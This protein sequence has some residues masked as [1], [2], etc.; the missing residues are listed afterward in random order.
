MKRIPFLLLGVLLT[1]ACGSKPIEAKGNGFSLTVP[2]GWRLTYELQG[3]KRIP[4]G[5]VAL[6]IEE[7]NDPKTPPTLI[8]Q[9]I[10]PKIDV[11]EPAGCKQ[12]GAVFGEEEKAE[13]RRT[14]VVDGSRGKSCEAELFFTAKNVVG[15]LMVVQT[16]KTTLLA[17]C[18]HAP[19]ENIAAACRRIVDTIKLD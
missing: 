1:Q 13:V 10:T 11:F 5:M 12:L 18:N 17:H 15:D 14:E 16:E 2:A 4:N 9:R 7:P 3:G 19:G 6:T 8:L